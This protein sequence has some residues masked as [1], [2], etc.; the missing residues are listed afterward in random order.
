MR[1]RVLLAEAL[2]AIA[3]SGAIGL[4][5]AAL[6]YHAG[7]A[8]LYLAVALAPGLFPSGLFSGVLAGD[9]RYWD[10]QILPCSHLHEGFQLLGEGDPPDPPSSQR[11][12]KE[13]G[14]SDTAH[15]AVARGSSGP[16][17]AERRCAS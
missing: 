17:V 8:M 5:I 6:T 13:A 1:P 2:A 11:R 9:L 16:V 10:A 4:G 7:E 12:G 15:E 3:F 14:R